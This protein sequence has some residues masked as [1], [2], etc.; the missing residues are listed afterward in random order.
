MEHGELD[1]VDENPAPLSSPPSSKTNDFSDDEDS[2]VMGFDSYADSFEGSA[3]EMAE[4]VTD[5]ASDLGAD[6]TLI[7]DYFGFD[8]RADTFEGEAYELAQVVTSESS[9]TVRDEV[10]NDEESNFDVGSEDLESDGFAGSIA[11]PGEGTGFDGAGEDMDLSGGLS[12]VVKDVYRPAEDEENIEDSATN[13]SGTPNIPDESN[14][15]DAFSGGTLGDFDEGIETDTMFDGDSLIDDIEEGL[16]PLDDTVDE[17]EMAEAITDNETAPKTTTETEEELSSSSSFEP[18]D[19]SEIEYEAELLGEDDVAAPS[20]A[21]TSDRDAPF[22]S[23][24]AD[25]RTAADGVVHVDSRS[26]DS[27]Y[28]VLAKA[29]ALYEEATEDRETYLSILKATGIVEQ[30]RAPFTPVIKLVFGKDYDKTRI[31]EYASALSFAVRQEQTSD[32]VQEFLSNYP[33][34]IKGCVK[35]ERIAKREEKG[36]TGDRAF[37]E[38]KE[39]LTN[40]DAISSGKLDALPE[41]EFFLLLARH[42][43]TPD[44]Y[45]ILKI[46]DEKSSVTTPIIKRAAKPNPD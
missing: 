5:E 37:E 24:L 34:G 3:Y 6:H 46:I 42:G 9:I 7:D 1:N 25:S 36:M 11:E 28:S 10:G 16:P 19:G 23:I 29:L 45:E 22:F 40:M 18:S 39:N 44:G 4:I 15:L 30:A 20:E 38:A 8:G 33:G 31:T 12:A 17:V 21:L 35:A 13:D 14:S 2:S 27:L 26:R 41:D 43:K 32:T